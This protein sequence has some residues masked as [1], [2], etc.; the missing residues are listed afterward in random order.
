MCLFTSLACIWVVTFHS[1][2]IIITRIV[3][4]L[5]YI[6][7]NIY[8]EPFISFSGQTLS[9]SIIKVFSLQFWRGMMRSSLQH[10]L[11]LS[12]K[13]LCFNCFLTICQCL[14]LCRFMCR[15]YFDRTGRNEC[16]H[17]LSINRRMII[18]LPFRQTSDLLLTYLKSFLSIIK[19]IYLLTLKVT[20]L[21]T[22]AQI[23]ILLNLWLHFYV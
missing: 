5:L 2:L 7:I 14:I 16:T 19:A 21:D 10:P 4:W 20:V 3:Y 13:I 11:G 12:V 22:K 1:N 8:N 18:W 15:N 9:V 23:S 6:Y 17:G